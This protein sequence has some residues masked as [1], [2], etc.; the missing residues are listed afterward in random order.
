[1]FRNTKGGEISALF[2]GYIETGVV[3][4]VFESGFEL[5]KSIRGAGVKW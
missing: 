5:S 1:M 3:C 2:Q 4:T